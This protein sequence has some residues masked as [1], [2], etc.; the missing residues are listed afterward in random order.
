MDGLGEAEAW[1]VWKSSSLFL[2]SLL[3]RLCPAGC[4]MPDIGGLPLEVE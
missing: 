4:A 2:S 3:S 1:P